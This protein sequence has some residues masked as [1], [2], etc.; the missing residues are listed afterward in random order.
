MSAPGRILFLLHAH[1][2]F[3]RHPGYDRFFEENWLFEAISETYLPLVQAMRRLL[4]K[5]V[6]GM[7][8]LSV[9]PPLIEMLRD[10]S[11]IAKFSNH[12]Q[13]QLE[14][15]EHEAAR[16]K[17]GPQSTLANFYLEREKAL[18][19]LWEG[20]LHRNLLQ[21]FSALEKAGKLNLLTCVG[22]HPFLPAYQSDP[23]S[24]RMQLDAT[25]KCFESAFG[26]KP[27]GVWLPECGYFPSLDRYLAEFG[28]QYFFLETHGVLL[29]SPP[30]KYGVFTPLRTKSGL[31][32]MGREQASSMEVW[33]RRTGY[34]GHPEYREFFK[35]IAQERE[36]AYLG[37]YFYSGDTPI[38]TGFKYYRITGS[39]QK[40]FYRPWNAMRLVQDH[41]R[42][43]IANRDAT[44]SE[45]IPK[46][47]GNK[48]ALLC[49]YDA[50]LFGHWW[51][52]GPLF[53]EALLERAAASSVLEFA[54]A[55]SVMTNSADP[56]AHEPAFSSWG[57]GGFG[58]VWINSE[59]EQFY[60]QSYRIR[61][62]INYLKGEL[63]KL[64]DSK[65]VSLL[66]RYVRQMERELMLFQSSDWAFM[67]HNKSSDG[68]ARRR[69]ETHYLGAESLF[70]EAR[71]LLADYKSGS[72]H[73]KISTPVLAE[74]EK[75]DNIFSR[76]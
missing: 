14:L 49:P 17:D 10:E 68:Y 56:D 62:R 40:E 16:F 15:A 2:P 43:F 4:E 26:R 28:L 42:L 34:P 19:E 65:I 21:E 33:S 50:E 51:F 74:L 23:D 58:S 48:A 9:S 69:L 41:A 36:R 18:I 57:E 73:G 12:L 54:G 20:R 61:A 60:P 75:N 64:E 35:D 72:I 67:I 44:L 76:Q 39:E 11:L 5:G 7:L 31:Y 3:V 13:K 63:S 45:L 59:T 52:E 38:D 53:L 6:P 55:D 66:E 71:M 24:I 70:G 22:T 32:C 37:E 30:P 25:I 1:L 8:N 47:D 46:M 29:A 27:K